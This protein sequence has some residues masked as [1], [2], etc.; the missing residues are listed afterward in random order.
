MS[1]A[2]LAPNHPP[3]TKRQILNY[4]FPVLLQ[5]VY[6]S[7]LNICKVSLQSIIFMYLYLYSNS[8][9]PNPLN[10]LLNPTCEKKNVIYFESENLSQCPRDQLYSCICCS[11]RC[12]KKGTTSGEAS[13]VEDSLCDQEEMPPRAQVCFLACAN[14]CVTAPW[15]PWSNCPPVRNSNGVTDFLG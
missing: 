11:A 12:V 3:R 5:A 1:V 2:K 10:E 4:Q 15:G 14:D 9:Y 6:N 7:T 8:L 13:S